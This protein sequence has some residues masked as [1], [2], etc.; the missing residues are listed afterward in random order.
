MWSP[1]MMGY[2]PIQAFSLLE[3]LQ[4][5]KLLLRWPFR[6][7]CCFSKGHRDEC[8]DWSGHL[9]VIKSCTYAKKSKTALIFFMFSVYLPLNG[10]CTRFLSVCLDER[11]ECCNLYIRLL[12]LS[13]INSL[14]LTGNT[15]LKHTHAAVILYKTT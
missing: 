3:L 4:Q 14:I 11:I 9:Q 2:H 15:P 5:P 12:I 6:T 7:H 13:P 10:V 1:S 8:E